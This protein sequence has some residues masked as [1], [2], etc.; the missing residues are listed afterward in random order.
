MNAWLTDAVFDPIRLPLDRL[1][2][3]AIAWLTTNYRPTFQAAK[4]PIEW[5]LATLTEL[6]TSF[7]PIA[8]IPLIVAFAARVAGW[9]TAAFAFA[10]FLTIGMV[11]LW[12]PTMVTLA[13]VGAAVVVCV[14]IGLPLGILA[15]RSDRFRAILRPMLDVMQTT[16]AFVYLVPVV[17]LFSIGSVAG[18]I[19]TI[20]FALPPLIRLTDLGIR[21]V[22]DD[23]IEAAE[24]FGVSRWQLLRKVQLPLALPVIMA[25]VNQTI[26]LSLSMVVIA[27]LIGAGGLGR[28]VVEGLNAL[29]VGQAGIGGLAIVLLAIVLDRLTQAFAQ[30]RDRPST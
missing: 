30:R 13:M 1:F 24:A 25:G 5:L 17:M 3:D 26:M 2:A 14:I 18:V 8:F 29:R 6:L 28:P 7:P 21:G 23:V 12:R 10:A 19:A 4:V 15:A 16:P 22:P 11:G 9:R 27:A 20:I